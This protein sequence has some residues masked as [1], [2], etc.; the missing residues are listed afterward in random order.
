MVR[1]EPRK[2]TRLMMNAVALN[3]DDTD[4]PSEMLN[5]VPYSRF[6]IMYDITEVGVLVNNDRIRIQVQFRQL[7]G[8]LWRTLMN[9]PFGALYEEESTTP[10][11]LSV[12][13][14]C[15]GE[16][17]RIVVTTDYTNAD[18]SANYF[19]ITVQITLLE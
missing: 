12:S 1:V 17:M 15:E 2:T 11:N 18:P 14:P 4:F 3:V 19:V 13:G 5:C 9:G 8:V 7:N 16:E 10:C 6:L